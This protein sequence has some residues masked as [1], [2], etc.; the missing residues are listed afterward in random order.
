MNI[1]DFPISGKI[2]LVYKRLGYLFKD[3]VYFLY[4]CSLYL[5]CHIYLLYHFKAD[6]IAFLD[7]SRVRTKSFIEG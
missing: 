2:W 5:V 6:S 7:G 1:E 4:I 3:S